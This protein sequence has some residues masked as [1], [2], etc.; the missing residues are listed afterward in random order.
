MTEPPQQI[1]IVKTK[2][3]NYV[4]LIDCPEYM[5]ARACY[6][7]IDAEKY[8]DERVEFFVYQWKHNK[9]RFSIYMDREP[10]EFKSQEEVETF[11]RKHYHIEKVYL[12]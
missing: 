7:R 9:E 6:T 11:A 1:F 5:I 12:F 8:I 2:F 10:E 3:V 4:S